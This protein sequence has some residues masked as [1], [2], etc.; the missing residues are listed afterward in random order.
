VKRA[1]ARVDVIELIQL[2]EL[3]GKPPQFFL[4]PD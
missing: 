3:Y 2:A 1:N 4:N